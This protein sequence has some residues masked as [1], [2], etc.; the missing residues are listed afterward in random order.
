MQ[1]Q[2]LERI[3]AALTRLEAGEYGICDECEDE[4]PEARLR[5]LPFATRCRACQESVEQ[6]EQRERRS[7]Q[8]QSA[9]RSRSLTEVIGL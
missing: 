8:R 7:G 2:T 5:A 6:V 1:A 9:F 3:N 4:I